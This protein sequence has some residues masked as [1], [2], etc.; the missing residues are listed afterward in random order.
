MESILLLNV[1]VGL[2]LVV[3]WRNKTHG[4]KCAISSRRHWTCASHISLEFNTVLPVKVFSDYITKYI[5]KH[6]EKKRSFIQLHENMET[7]V[8]DT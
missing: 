4:P 6:R 1:S 3:T 7:G 5:S 2:H 8:G